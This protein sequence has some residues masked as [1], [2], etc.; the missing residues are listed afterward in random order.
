MTSGPSASATAARCPPAGK[1]S[2]CFRRAAATRKGSGTSGSLLP[3]GGANT[4]FPRMSFT[5]WTTCSV[6]GPTSHRR[7]ACPRISPCRSRSRV[8]M[9]T[10]ARYRSGRAVRTA[11][12]LRGKPGH[13]AAGRQRSAAGRTAPR[14][15]SA[16]DTRRR[17]RHDSTAA[18]VGVDG[19]RV[20]AL[21]RRR[22][23]ARRTNSRMCTGRNEPRGR[24][25][26]CGKAWSRSWSLT[27]T[28]VFGSVAC[29]TTQR[30]AYCWK[31]MTSGLGVDVLP[32]Q[33]VG[34]RL[35]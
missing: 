19:P 27:A 15:D 2:M 31:V 4:A 32:A 3:L 26:R 6:W 17:R 14:T 13:D 21:D 29:G 20:G 8:P 1:V 16:R 33:H 18:H 25:P 28:L 35:R 5:C 11:T 30:S 12:H 24:A 10:M 9:S 34:F 22:L 7:P 23:P